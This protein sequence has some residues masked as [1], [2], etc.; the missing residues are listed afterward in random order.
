MNIQLIIGFPNGETFKVPLSYIRPLRL[1]AI[2]R[3]N[4][5]D[6][7]LNSNQHSEVVKWAWKNLTWSQ[8]ENHCDPKPPKHKYYS[9]MWAANKCRITYR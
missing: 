6:R 1:E 8:L 2:R 7:A 4:P 3:V 5:Y 9:A